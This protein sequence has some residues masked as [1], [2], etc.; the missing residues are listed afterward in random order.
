METYCLD[1]SQEISAMTVMKEAMETAATT[2]LSIQGKLKAWTT[3]LK[4]TYKRSVQ[5]ERELKTNLVEKVK[6]KFEQTVERKHPSPTP[7]T[8]IISYKV[9]FK[10][11]NDVLTFTTHEVVDEL[12]ADYLKAVID[13]YPYTI[14]IADMA[15]RLQIKAQHPPP[16]PPVH[17][18]TSLK[19]NRFKV[20]PP[21]AERGSDWN[22]YFQ[23]TGCG[24]SG[25][26]CRDYPAA[27]AW[28][29]DC[30]NGEWKVEVKP[31]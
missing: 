7:T 29:H 27:S 14:A 21:R 24:E 2:D 18:L 16:P 22:W 19:L 11:Q 30:P 4:Q 31:A 17:D 15:L 26:V 28:P 3:S 20:Q 9:S 23:C 6:E 10:F 5:T 1:I 25:P 13:E 8:G 12:N